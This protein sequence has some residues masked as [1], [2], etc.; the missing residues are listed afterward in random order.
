MK[1]GDNLINRVEINPK[2]SSRTL[3]MGA[4]P[5]LTKHYQRNVKII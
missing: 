5:L 4:S 3:I 1:L 2:G